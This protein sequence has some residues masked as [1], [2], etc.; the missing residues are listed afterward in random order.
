[1]I[2]ARRTPASRERER[3]KVEGFR[4]LGFRGL[5]V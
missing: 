1:M 3:L 2:G 5:K 4:V